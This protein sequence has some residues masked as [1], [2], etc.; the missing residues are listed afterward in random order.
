M[1]NAPSDVKAAFKRSM[2][3]KVDNP[4]TDVTEAE[5]EP[6]VDVAPTPT[7]AEIDATFEKELEALQRSEAETK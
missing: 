1:T 4:T 2:S 6:E 5:P 7:V 3:I